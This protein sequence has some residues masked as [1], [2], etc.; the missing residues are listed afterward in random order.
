MFSMSVT[1]TWSNRYHER[2]SGIPVSLS[3]DKL[4]VN[5]ETLLDVICSVFARLRAKDQ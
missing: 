1:K 2:I 4:H 3:Q 5:P